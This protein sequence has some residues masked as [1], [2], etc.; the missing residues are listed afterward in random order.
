[1]RMQAGKYVDALVSGLPKRNGWTI[2]EH[3]G[4][5]A[6]D[7]TDLGAQQVSNL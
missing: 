5:R 6:P 7:R 2:V 1:M 3:A 4:D